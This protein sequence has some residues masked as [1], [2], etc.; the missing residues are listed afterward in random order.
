MIMFWKIKI[1]NFQTCGSSAASSSFAGVGSSAGFEVVVGSGSCSL[2]SLRI[3][4]NTK[5]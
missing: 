3:H 2:A 1:P 5:D 4:Y